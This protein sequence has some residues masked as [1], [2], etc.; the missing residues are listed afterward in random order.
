MLKNLLPRE[1]L[2]IINNFLIEK[3]N[4]D[5]L[6]KSIESLPIYEN[7]SNSRHEFNFYHTNI[8]Y[9]ISFSSIHYTS[10]KTMLRI[11]LEKNKKKI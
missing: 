1:I 11:A 4:H 6:V 5:Q 9:G 3:D 2:N 10:Y 7:G 8:I